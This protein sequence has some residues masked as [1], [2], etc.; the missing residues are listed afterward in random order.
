L[1]ILQNYLLNQAFVDIQLKLKH[2]C[3]FYMAFRYTVL[4]YICSI[5]HICAVIYIYVS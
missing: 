5:V 2:P 3:L 4:S 1:L